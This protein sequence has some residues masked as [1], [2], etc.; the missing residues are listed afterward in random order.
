VSPALI[1]ILLGLTPVAAIACACAITR[2]R[3]RPEPTPQQR[4]DNVARVESWW[5]W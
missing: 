2:G 3:Q 1:A 5:T 4:E